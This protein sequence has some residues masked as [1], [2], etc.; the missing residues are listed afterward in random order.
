MTGTADTEAAEFAQIYKLE[1]LVI[2]PTAPTSART[3]RTPSTRPSARSSRRCATTS[4]SAGRR[5]SRCWVGTVS[6]A[7]SEV[8]LNLLKKRGVPHDVLNAKQHE[9]EAEI[10]AQAGARAGSPS[11]PTWR[12][13]TDILLG[14]NPEFLAK[15]EV[16]AEPSL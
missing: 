7:K 16:G 3:C 10:V 2:P 11:P 4:K 15:R 14:G 12:R 8:A 13:G 6:I 5:A 1:V 9:R